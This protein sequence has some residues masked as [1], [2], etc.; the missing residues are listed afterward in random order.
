MMEKYRARL[1]ID[2]H[3]YPPD[4]DEDDNDNSMAIMGDPEG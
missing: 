1:I 4:T 2:A 3:N